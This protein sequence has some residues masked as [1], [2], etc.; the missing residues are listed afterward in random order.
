MELLQFTRQYRAAA[1]QLH[2]LLGQK[3]YHPDYRGRWYD[4]LALNLDYHL[5]QPQKLSV[6]D[7]ETAV[8]LCTDG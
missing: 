6:M 2:L 4:R 3:V 8:R 7:M 1:E 5:K